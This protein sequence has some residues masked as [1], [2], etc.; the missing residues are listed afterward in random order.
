MAY[1]FLKTH[2]FDHLL[3]LPAFTHRLELCYSEIRR[4]LKISKDAAMRSGFRVDP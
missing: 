1:V 3:D 2:D 4:S